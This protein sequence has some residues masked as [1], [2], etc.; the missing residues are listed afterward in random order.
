MRTV[1][2]VILLGIASSGVSRPQ[3]TLDE[4]YV[5][6]MY[7][8]LS[9]ET[10]WKLNSVLKIDTPF[11]LYRD[12]KGQVHLKIPIEKTITNGRGVIFVSTSG[13]S[14]KVSVDGSTIP[15]Y[16]NPP[17]GPGPCVDPITELEY[18]DAAYSK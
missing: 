12:D 4:V 16:V 18:G 7:S 11:M 6:N 14:T 8:A 1:I 9:G 5:S 3:A 13:I 10:V 17:A 2:T 15:F